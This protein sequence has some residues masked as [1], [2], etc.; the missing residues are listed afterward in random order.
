M[1]SGLGSIVGEAGSYGEAIER[2]PA[3]AF[4]VLLLDIELGDGTG[5]DVLNGLP[6]E[7]RF[8]VIFATAYDAHA[9][10]AFEFAALDYLL[11]PIDPARLQAAL[12]RATAGLSHRETSLR[13]AYAKRLLA[14]Q[15]N[16]LV[17][18][19]VGEIDWI[20][21]DRNY[22]V[23][24][25]RGQEYLLRATLENLLGRLDPA[26]FRRVNRS[27]AVRLSAIDRLERSADGNWLLYLHS[28]HVLTASRKFWA[29]NKE[30]PIDWL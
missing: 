27:A 4:D 23:L 12:L 5:F 10:R 30:G 18:L 7:P 3:A 19:A 21:A 16:A 6:E 20:E 13:P 22:L 8:A 26:Q 25:A 29:P 11:K 14:S 24:H 1:E 17:P 2:I 9:L 28:K 15:R